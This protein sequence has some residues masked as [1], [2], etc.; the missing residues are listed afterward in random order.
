MLSWM[1]M[2]ICSSG[3][4]L[5][6]SIL[7]GW[8]CWICSL[9]YAI[10]FVFERMS[11]PFLTMSWFFLCFTSLSKFISSYF[12]PFKSAGLHQ[13]STR[14]QTEWFIDYLAKNSA[15]LKR[16]GAVSLSTI[17]TEKDLS[18]SQLYLYSVTEL[19]RK[20]LFEWTLSKNGEI[21]SHSRRLIFST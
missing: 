15:I 6:H 3:K 2:F 20:K 7:F 21:T 10:F 9:R 11:F 1:E 4:F 18:F 16:F 12:F 14:K 19:G 8:F 13:G 17:G 5:F